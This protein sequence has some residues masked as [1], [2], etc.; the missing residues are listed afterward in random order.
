MAKGLGG[1]S[2]QSTLPAWGPLP[3]SRLLNRQFVQFA[4]I[5]YPSF[6]RVV[7][8]SRLP[9]FPGPVRRCSLFKGVCRARVPGSGQVPPFVKPGAW[10]VPFFSVHVSPATPGAHQYLQKENSRVPRLRWFSE[11]GRPF[12]VCLDTKGGASLHLNFCQG[13]CVV[14]LVAALAVVRD[15]ET[16][17]N[18]GLIWVAFLNH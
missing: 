3:R 14:F 8:Q 5:F 6:W 7:I 13:I 12:G 18:I 16:Q 10:C 15:L 17:A 1:L 9:P 4:I 2:L 11:P